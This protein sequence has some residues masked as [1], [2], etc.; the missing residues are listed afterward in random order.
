MSTVA[1]GITYLSKLPG[2]VSEFEEREA[3]RFGHYNWTAWQQLSYE[4][5][6]FGVAH[7]RMHYL[8]ELHQNDAQSKE[9]E[10]RQKN[11]QQG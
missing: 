7:Y 9:L 3:A 2:L 5:R 6:A 4:D 8:V 1:T 11:A 10:R